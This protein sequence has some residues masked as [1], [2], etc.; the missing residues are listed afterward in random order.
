M[1][2]IKSNPSIRYKSSI[3]IV[4][5]NSKEEQFNRDN[6]N[7]YSS[8]NSIQFKPQLMAEQK[9]D[10]SRLVT[11]FK[12]PE[13][14]YYAFPFKQL[15]NIDKK[16]ILNAKFSNIQKYTFRE[17]VVSKKENMSNS[18]KTKVKVMN[19]IEKKLKPESGG[20][21][22]LSPKQ[23]MSLEKVKQINVFK[24]SSQPT[25][26]ISK[27]NLC[28]PSGKIHVKFPLKTKLLPKNRNE[29][30]GK[31]NQKQILDQGNIDENL[32]TEEQDLDKTKLYD[33]NQLIELA[34][35]NYFKKEYPRASVN[36]KLVIEPVKKESVTYP[37]QLINMKNKIKKLSFNPNKSFTYV[38]DEEETVGTVPYID[39]QE[40]NICT[41]TK[42][43]MSHSTN[44]SNQQSLKNLYFGHHFRLQD[45]SE[46]LM[47]LVLRNKSFSNSF[48]PFLEAEEVVKL[49]AAHPKLYS[50][51]RIY[52]INRVVNMILNKDNTK[53]SSIWR[54]IYRLSNIKIS[55]LRET[56]LSYLNKPTKFV[57]EIEKD[58]YRTMPEEPTF[59]ETSP[60]F[61]KLR[62]VLIAYSNYNPKVGYCQGMNFIVA[63][64]ILALSKEEEVFLFLDS[65]IKR[66][67]MSKIFSSY[68]S[69]VLVKLERMDKLIRRF[70]PTLHMFFESI[71]INHEFFTTQWIITLFASAVH[72]PFLYKLWD[73]LIVYGWD[74]FFYFVLQVLLTFEKK[75]LNCNYY[76]LS[77]FV[78]AIMRTDDF[79][80][81]F[82][83]II[84]KT[85]EL[86][87]KEGA[88]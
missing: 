70:L 47:S 21:F 20:L 74:F 14:S 60:N 52:R 44:P 22:N 43:P 48:L 28:S 24:S 35:T 6:S 85:F 86:M 38:S 17:E 1:D 59:K 31:G 3:N 71:Y 72:I 4:S 57:E 16:S 25:K 79:C 88:L 19:I 29:T 68:N 2:S 67:G 58:V 32:P 87:E 39:Y 78:K 9:K 34:N 65:L 46:C 12:K 8:T 56:Y 76:N 84:H 62:S 49:S 55:K 45:D 27:I 5:V 10:L 41:K 33:E 66:F 30:I 7:I 83:S 75:I 53:I 13:T 82:A 80:N 23:L 73:F 81:S 50:H 77:V 51:L 42:S 11:Q 18:A 54:S 69:E 63:W 37:I 40:N 26:K 15:E 61:I 36:A 64:A